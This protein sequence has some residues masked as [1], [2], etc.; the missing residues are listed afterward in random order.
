ME[1]PNLSGYRRKA[2]EELLQGRKSAKELKDLLRQ[3]PGTGDLVL[4]EKILSSFANSIA[5]LSSNQPDEVSQNLRI[6]SEDSGDSI[7]SSRRKDGRG[8]Y[9]RR[10]CVD[11]WVKEITSLIDD[12]HS[13]RKYGQKDILKAKHPR[14]YYRCTH[15]FDQSCPATKQVQ[16][17]EDNPPK[18]R[19]VYYG[20]HTC[21]NLLNASQLLL[22]S[23]STHTDSSFLLNFETGTATAA[24]TPAGVKTQS[25]FSSF[26]SVKQEYKD[27]IPTE[28]ITDQHHQSSSTTTKSDYLL[29]PEITSGGI[30]MLSSPESEP[31]LDVFSGVID[32]FLFDDVFAS[33]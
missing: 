3:T 1:S 6:K 20:H 7:K 18:Y 29:S 11:S 17:I 12:G 31:P 10:R 28:L 16:Q 26:S 8:C 9:K 5:M 30:M 33:L 21:M 23:A 13:W 24:A 4:V 32:S 15:K 25:P 2:V 14:S 27:N 19:I 22:D